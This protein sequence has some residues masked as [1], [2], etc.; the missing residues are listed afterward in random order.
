MDIDLN[1]LV[2]FNFYSGWREIKGYYS[3]IL[4]KD[5]SL[6]NYF[7]LELFELH[8]KLTINQIS[9]KMDLD[10]SAVSCLIS[11]MEKSGLVKRT[12]D[13]NDRRVVHVHL[14][15][16]GE[17][18][19]ARLQADLSLQNHAELNISDADAETLKRIVAKFKTSRAQNNHK[20]S[21]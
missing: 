2:C 17:K 19:K 11:R 20:S 1:N 9:K 21:C 7:I 13:K 6:Q 16:N 4:G 14:T 18:L 12:R 8:E 10:T 5:I 3:G 15:K